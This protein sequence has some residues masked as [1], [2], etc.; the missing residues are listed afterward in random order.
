M[1]SLAAG[2]HLVLVALIQ[3]A[4]ILRGKVARDDAAAV[5]IIGRWL[6][7]AGACSVGWSIWQ[8]AIRSD[9]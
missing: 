1:P 8:W 4:E 6:I 3:I 5:I 2:P 9:S 7:F